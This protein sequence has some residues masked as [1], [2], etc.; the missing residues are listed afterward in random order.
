[1]A[2]MGGEKGTIGPGRGQRSS[3]KA[4]APP[5]GFVERHDGR[6]E[7]KI[8]EPHGLDRDRVVLE[9]QDLDRSGKAAERRNGDIDQTA[10]VRAQASRIVDME[11]TA[12]MQPHPGRHQR[13]TDLGP[14][15]SAGR[16][17]GA[18][19]RHFLL[20]RAVERIEHRIMREDDQPLAG[21][22]RPGGEIGNPGQEK[23]LVLQESIPAGGGAVFEGV[24]PVDGHED[25]GV[26]HDQPQSLLRLHQIG[27]IHQP[28]QV[29]P[30]R[31]RTS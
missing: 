18:D 11:M 26:D 3:L 23:G 14:R 17:G 16:F 9:G 29:A 10:T 5:L 31:E 21:G 30:E 25:I 2:E 8:V 13:R 1:M 24:A 28:P 12:E 27:G 15:N 20:P 19:Q 22:V 6:I 7:R 4:G